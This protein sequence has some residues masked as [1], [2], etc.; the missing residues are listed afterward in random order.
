MIIKKVDLVIWGKEFSMPVK[1]ADSVEIKDFADI[2]ET[3]QRFI[4]DSADITNESISEV[5]EYVEKIVKA[6]GAIAPEN[7]FECITPHM[8]LVN[9]DEG[10]ALIALLCGFILD[11]EHDIAMVFCNNTLVEVGSQDIISWW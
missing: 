2:D 7:M 6:I 9:I 4:A 1:Y 3:I 11:T 5:K 10:S 8:L